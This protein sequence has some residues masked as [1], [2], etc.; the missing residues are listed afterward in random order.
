MISRG[1][2]IIMVRCDVEVVRPLLT[3]STCSKQLSVVD[4]EGKPWRLHSGN[5]LLTDY[6]EK[7]PCGPPSPVFA[8]K[9]VEGSYISQS[10]QLQVVP[11]NLSSSS[12]SNTIPSFLSLEEDRLLTPRLNPF[13]EPGGLY[14][15]EEIEGDQE[16][17]LREWSLLV[18]TPPAA[19]LAPEEPSPPASA[20]SSAHT[21]AFQSNSEKALQGVE[22]FLRGSL[23][24][25]IGRGLSMM[26][27]FILTMLLTLGNLWAVVLLFTKVGSTI[28]HLFGCIGPGSTQS[29]QESLCW[30]F[31]GPLKLATT[32]R[33][34]FP[35]APPPPD[36]SAPPL[37]QEAPDSGAGGDEGSPPP[38]P[39]SS[40]KSLLKWRSSRK[41]KKKAQAPAV[42]RPSDET[43]THLGYKKYSAAG[44][45]ALPPTSSVERR[46]RQ[47]NFGMVGTRTDPASILPDQ[48]ASVQPSTQGRGRAPSAPRRSIH[49]E[50]VEILL[51]QPDA[52]TSDLAKV[53]FKRGPR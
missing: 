48:V 14:S 46:R 26:E 35:A 18:G 5:R 13:H 24:S 41:S 39:S 23:R 11:L 9:T 42:P 20:A 45:T 6:G 3:A 15:E 38:A 53:F 16:Q 8:F 17:Y 32:A 10:P 28:A 33:R 2:L 40:S 50:E 30:A 37:E 44:P 47:A 43:L 31:C 25:L 34:G 4:S 22:A 36:P 29:W 19:L 1:E 27:N 7:V 12:R 51:P 21:R 52:L 49:Q